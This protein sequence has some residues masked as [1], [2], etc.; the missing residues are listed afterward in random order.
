MISVDSED[1]ERASKAHTHIVSLASAFRSSSVTSMRP[2]LKIGG[3]QANASA[4]SGKRIGSWRAFRLLLRRSLTQMVRDKF[5]TSLRFLAIAGLSLIFTAHFGKLD[6]GGLPTARSVASR[7][8][9]VSFGVIAMAMLACARALDRFAKERGVVARERAA[10]RYH[11]AV[12]LT[13]K[14]VCELPTDA[15]FSALFAVVVREQCGLHAEL[16]RVV[17]AFALVA[18]TC[19]SLGL[20]IGA[21][22]PRADTAIAVGAPVMA[23]HM[24]TGVIDP[25]GQAGNDPGSVIQLLRYL[26]PIRHGIEALCVAELE[27]MTLARSAA[28]APRMGGLALIR[29]GDEVLRR[30]DVTSSFDGCMRWLAGLACLHLAAAALALKVTRPQFSRTAPRAMLGAFCPALVSD[31]RNVVPLRNSGPEA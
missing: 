2:C 25:A 4:R 16:G 21:A 12:Y 28:D 18:V 26:S 17:G 3:N 29:T 13:A 11:G 7:I 9:L 30:L 19:A 14:V 5:T 23:V 22:A 1:V 20:A 8:C 24:L 10:R 15:A 31:R 6:G 27:G